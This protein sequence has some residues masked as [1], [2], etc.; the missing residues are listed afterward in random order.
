MPREQETALLIGGPWDGQRVVTYPGQ[1]MVQMLKPAAPRTLCDED[2]APR[3]AAV[4]LVAYKL[5]TFH[6]AGGYTCIIGTPLGD[7]R[8]PMEILFDS[9]RKAGE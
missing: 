5:S 7:R 9:Y 8:D 4:D 6:G 3:D 2:A 1:R